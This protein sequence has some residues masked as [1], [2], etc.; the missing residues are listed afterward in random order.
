[1][2][3]AIHV[4]VHCLLLSG[5]LLLLLCDVRCRGVAR[6]HVHAAVRRAGNVLSLLGLRCL[7]LLSSLL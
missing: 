6:A 3:W 2:T 1:M 5:L 7:G 4:A